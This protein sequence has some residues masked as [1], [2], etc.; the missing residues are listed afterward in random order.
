[1]YIVIWNKQGEKN[2]GVE[3]AIMLQKLY[4]SESIDCASCIQ[5]LFKSG[6]KLSGLHF[7]FPI[8]KMRELNK[9]FKDF[10]GR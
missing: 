4:F 5:L 6:C 8:S 1:M 10:S 9:T 3:C 2:T 7:S